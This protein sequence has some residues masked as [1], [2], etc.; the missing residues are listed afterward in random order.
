MI[1]DSKII[2]SNLN[3]QRE[4]S[5][6]T[7]FGSARIIHEEV[8]FNQLK[9]YHVLRVHNSVAD[10]LA[11]ASVELRFGQLSVDRT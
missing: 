8:H 6:N 4:A 3:L 2:I 9:Y 11:N 7:C 1:G 5:Q 10:I